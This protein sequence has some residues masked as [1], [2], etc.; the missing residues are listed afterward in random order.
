MEI[1]RQSKITTHWVVCC[2]ALPTSSMSTTMAMLIGT[3]VIGT[4]TCAR[5]GMEGVTK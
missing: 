2:M 3:N 5:S 1:K 4:G